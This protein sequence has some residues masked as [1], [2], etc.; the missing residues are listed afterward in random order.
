MWES[1]AVRV[2]WCSLCQEQVG[3]GLLPGCV[4]VYVFFFL[5][6]MLSMHWPGAT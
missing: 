4:C 2:A 5:V 6:L 1:E 3:V